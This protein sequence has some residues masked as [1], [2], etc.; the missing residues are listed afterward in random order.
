MTIYRF[1]QI[2]VNANDRVDPAETGLEHYVGLEHLDPESLKI[3]H[4]GSPSDVIGEKLRFRK[5]DIIFGRRRAYQR[6]LAV[7]EFDGICS[8][9]AMVLRPKPDVVLPEFLPFFMQSDLFMNRALEISV[10]SLSPT[11]NWSALA[12]QEFALPP[13]EEQRR[14]ANLLWEAENL[15][16]SYQD[17]LQKAQRLKRSAIY[18]H[19]RESETTYKLKDTEF[20]ELPETWNAEPLGNLLEVAQY[21]LSMPL[22]EKGK[23]PVFRMMNI[24]DGKMAANDMKYIDLSDGEFRTYKVNAGDIL[25]NRTNSADLVGKLGIFD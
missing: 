23:Y 17:I 12:Q 15:V 20:G 5:G 3:R 1:D 18:H 9:H 25:F 2:A 8:A 14:I 11:I 21:G 13:L 19:T 22:H 4:W 10:G 24:V 16:A 7:A 6:K